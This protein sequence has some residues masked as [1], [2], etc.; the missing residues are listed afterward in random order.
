MTSPQ[1]P[2][3][4][5]LEVEMSSQEFARVGMGFAYRRVRRVYEHALPIF[6]VFDRPLDRPDKIVVRLFLN[7]RPTNLAWF[8][9]TV[10][11]ARGAMP[12]GLTTI[13]R[14]AQDDAKIVECWL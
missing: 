12:L 4:V 10:D 1:P 8:F 13:P 3:E 2:G 7:D 14:A 6:V 11:E 5:T 9:A